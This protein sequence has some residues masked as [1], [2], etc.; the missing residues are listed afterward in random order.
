MIEFTGIRPGEKLYEEIF[1]GAEPPVPTE[2]D[3]ILIASP[4]LADHDELAGTIDA[5]K[6][7]AQSADE[8]ALRALIADV[9]P[10]YGKKD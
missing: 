4:R 3:G 10:E 8:E 5:L 1:H 6:I 2:A 7:A 9:V